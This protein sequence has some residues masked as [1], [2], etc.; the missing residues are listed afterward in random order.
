GAA[1]I[2]PAAI[3]KGSKSPGSIINPRPA[4]GI[5][6]G[7]VTVAIGSPIRNNSGRHPH[8]S[9]SGDYAPATVTIQIFV[10]DHLRRYVPDRYYAALTL[11]A[12][13][14][15][16]IKA[17]EAGI[18]VSPVSE[19]SSIAEADSTPRFHLYRAT[20][21]GGDTLAVPD[22]DECGIALRIY[23]E[24]IAAGFQN[25]ERGVGRINFHDLAL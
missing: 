12:N 2:D 25:R 1:N 10:S 8:G 18:F 5:D 15:P 16:I 23:I 14:A 22:R 21:S 17:I 24:T 11:I 3:V 19:R 13:A 20:I 9:I 4:P 6:P 7:P